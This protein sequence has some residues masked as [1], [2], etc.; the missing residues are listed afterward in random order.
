MNRLIIFSIVVLIPCVS[1]AQNDRALAKNG[2]PKNAKIITLS[3]DQT[4]NELFEATARVLFDNGYEV[5]NSDKDTGIIQT[6]NKSIKGGWHLRLSISVTDK[7]VRVR[8]NIYIPRMMD[9][10]LE[11]Y[12]MRGS[13]NL[14]AFSEMDRIAKL[15]PHNS[16][17]Y[18]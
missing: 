16:I 14:L 7:S 13:L 9:D 12:G 15:I 18:L 2:L 8:G 11:N 17:E 10:D 4:K 3:S 6:D 5:K 1:F